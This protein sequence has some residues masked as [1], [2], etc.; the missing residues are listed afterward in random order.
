MCKFPS[1]SQMVSNGLLNDSFIE[2]LGVVFWSRIYTDRQKLCLMVGEIGCAVVVVVAV[3]VVSGLD[4]EWHLI[5]D[6]AG[7]TVWWQFANE[8]PFYFAVSK[9]V[10]L[11]WWRKLSSRSRDPIVVICWKLI[12]SGPVQWGE[13][14]KRHQ[15]RCF[16]KGNSPW[17]FDC[18]LFKFC[19][20]IESL[21]MN[22]ERG[23]SPY[24]QYFRIFEIFHRNELFI[25]ILQFCGKISTIPCINSICRSMQF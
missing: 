24:W 19:V 10:I 3:P 14:A 9:A 6:A 22:N 15:S 4:H 12:K 8:R 23:L 5:V 25:R 2:S 17:N 20:F 16:V 13:N 11:D 21:A 1:Q 18:S 7:V